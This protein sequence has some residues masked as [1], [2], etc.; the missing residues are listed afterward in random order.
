MNMLRRLARL[1]AAWLARRR[2]A[3]CHPYGAAGK[4]A[5]VDRG[6]PGDPHFCCIKGS[7]WTWTGIVRPHDETTP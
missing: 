6:G 1:P 7:H 5:A 2:R 3:G 4:G